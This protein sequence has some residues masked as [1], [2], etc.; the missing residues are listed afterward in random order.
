MESTT[1]NDNKVVI[2]TKELTKSVNEDVSTSEV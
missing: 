2:I 1:K